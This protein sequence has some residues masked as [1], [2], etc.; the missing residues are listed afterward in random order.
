MS[1]VVVPSAEPYNV[2]RC[3]WD[4]AQGTCLDLVSLLVVYGCLVP[5]L[6]VLG[7]LFGDVLVG[8]SSNGPVQF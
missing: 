3:G 4:I 7:L 6:E 1:L 8:L 2:L 5:G